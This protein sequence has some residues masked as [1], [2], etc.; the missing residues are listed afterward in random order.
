MLCSTRVIVSLNWMMGQFSG[1]PYCLVVWNIN[2]IVP[3]GISSSHLT[4]KNV[5]AKHHQPE[6]PPIRKILTHGLLLHLVN[7]IGFIYFSKRWLKQWVSSPPTSLHLMV[8]T[9]GFSGEDFSA[10]WKALETVARWNRSLQPW[11][12]KIAELSSFT[13]FLRK[14]VVDSWWFPFF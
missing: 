10:R 2:F 7:P 5:R 8:K 11:P 14:N 12:R 9:H 4:L 6:K 1:N 3:L 13:F